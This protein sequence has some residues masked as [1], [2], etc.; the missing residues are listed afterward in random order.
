[1]FCAVVWAVRGGLQSVYAA[2]PPFAADFWWWC[3]VDQ[4][5]G[6]LAPCGLTVCQGSCCR[7]RL[8]LCSLYGLRLG[9]VEI[10]VNAMVCSLWSHLWQF[11]D[12][13]R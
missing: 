3:V 6:T 5:L 9:R 10:V 8:A 7:C 12:Q 2:A 13:R 1:M 4:C 11:C